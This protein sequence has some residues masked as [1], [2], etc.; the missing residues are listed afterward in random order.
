MRIFLIEIGK[1]CNLSMV[2]SFYISYEQ[3]ARIMKKKAG[4]EAVIIMQREENRELVLP[5]NIRQM[6]VFG[7]TYK[8]Y[9]ED[10][11]YTYVH[12]FIH[13]RK[14][15]DLVL[16]AV[17][18]GKTVRQGEQ[19][20][21]FIS[22]AQKVEFQ[23][24][25]EVSDAGGEDGKAA[26]ETTEAEGADSRK[27][28]E[29][30]EDMIFSRQQEFWDR[31]YQ[32]IKQYFDDCEILGW[33]FNLDGSNLEIHS[34]LQ[35]FFE[36]TYKKG[37]RFLYFEDSLEKEDAF[38]VQEQHRLQRL[39]G[40]A[41]Y[42]EKN[43]Q[44]Q[45]FMIAEKERMAPRPLRE[46]YAREERDEVVQNYRAIM[47]KLNEKPA[48]KKLQ[49]AIYVAGVAV[50]AIVAATGVTQIG[51]Y[52]N[53][54]VLEQTMQ[55]LSGAVGSEDADTG[56]GKSQETSETPEETPPET[57]TGE[58]RAEETTAE[59]TGAETEET[60]Q[61]PSEPESGQAAGAETD[62]E[63]QAGTQAAGAAGADGD[64]TGTGAETASA[65]EPQAASEPS[66]YYIVKKGDSLVS[67]SEAI[68]QT[69]SRVED[70]CRLNQIENMDMIY[71]G[72]KLL[73][74]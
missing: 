62:A 48:R 27:E 55:T 4:K 9:V 54:K 59:E 17:L 72:Q 16:A 26:A 28:P 1:N 18:L 23:M 29:A 46:S 31:V 30:R 21:V 42:Y 67:I 68:Y 57:E 61:T 53:L 24:E 25:E 52:Q 10:F 74:P 40:Y 22:G 43:P 3:R 58:D 71:E 45:E 65:G 49:P 13:R 41:V 37:S 6:G 8:V 14:K 73:L 38:F 11:V 66:D 34:Q 32:R 51:N 60:E 33:Y 64:S 47:N 36:S 70:I 2:N 44:M 50:L 56:Q 35:Q 7:D 63:A 12:Q 20:Y 5:K 39:A 15:E 69:S 19:E